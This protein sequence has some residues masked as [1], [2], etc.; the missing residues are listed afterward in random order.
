M[1]HATLTIV[2]VALLATALPVTHASALAVREAAGDGWIAVQGPWYA[3]CTAAVNVLIVEST[4]GTDLVLEVVAPL[5]RDFGASP[6]CLQAARAASGAY[7]GVQGSATE[8][9]VYESTY[10]GNCYRGVQV[11]PID[12][13]WWA[14]WMYESCGGLYYEVQAYL[15][16]VVG[17]EV[18]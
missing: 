9:Y 16:P 18:A 5:D 15:L 8:G 3:N 7:T 12:G 17:P 2:L 6:P 11:S 14:F 13:G 4:D 10:L 1:R